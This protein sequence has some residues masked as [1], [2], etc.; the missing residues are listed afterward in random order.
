MCMVVIGG[1]GWWYHVASGVTS[2]FEQ[3]CLVLCERECSD[4][5]RVFVGLTL[6]CFMVILGEIYK[7]NKE[8][9]SQAILLVINIATSMVAYIRFGASCLAL[10]GMLSTTNDAVGITIVDLCYSFSGFLIDSLPFPEI[11]LCKFIRNLLLGLDF[12]Y[13]SI[14]LCL[15]SS[16]I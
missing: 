6:Y 4:G 9:G 14:C 2:L 13:V 1:A 8:S 7:C 3:W 5:V 15:L 10:Y 12:M 11:D 16:R